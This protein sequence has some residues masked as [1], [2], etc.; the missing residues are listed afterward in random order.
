MAEL[1][2]LMS[3]STTAVIGLGQLGAAVA[4]YLADHGADVIAVDKNMARVEALKD[5]VARAVCLDATDERALRAA[6]VADAGVV[7]LAL[8]EDQLEGAALT[9]MVLRELGVG[10]IISRA[11]SEIQA[12]VLERLGVSK[13]VFPERHMGVQI[14][15]QILNPS[16]VELLPL[17]RAASLGEVLVPESLAGQTIG[18][19]GMRKRFRLNVVA[20]KRRTKEVRDDGTVEQ[21]FEM[22]EQPGADTK[23]A[24]GDALVVVGTDQ[25]IR[26]FSES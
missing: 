24:V 20:I 11:G 16:V 6:G 13:V 9:A 3:M 26:A 18:E 17:S 21:G 25:D 14:A 2:Y 23:L 22:D 7:V 19:V 10:K 15:R 8:A 4:R 1:Q 12:K 5:H